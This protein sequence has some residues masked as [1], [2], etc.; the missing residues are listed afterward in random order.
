MIPT[1]ELERTAVL[2]MTAPIGAVG[3]GAACTRSAHATMYSA[4]PA[5]LGLFANQANSAKPWSMGGDL[6]V[7]RTT[8]PARHLGR[9]ST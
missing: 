8:R 3:I 9:S 2:P 7:N 4:F 1:T 5:V 6:Q